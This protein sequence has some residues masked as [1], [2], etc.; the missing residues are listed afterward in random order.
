MLTVATSRQFRWGSTLHIWCF[1]FLGI[2]PHH[3]PTAFS[4]IQTFTTNTH[5]HTCQK[6]RCLHEPAQAGIMITSWWPGC[7][8]SLSVGWRPWGRPA[9]TYSSFDRPRVHANLM[10][11]WLKGWNLR[12]VA[13][14]YIDSRWLVII[15][16]ETVESKPCICVGV[17][18]L[19]RWHQNTDW[20]DWSDWGW[21]YPSWH[22]DWHEWHGWQDCRDLGS[23]ET[24]ANK[25]RVTRDVCPA[26]GGPLRIQTWQMEISWTSANELMF[27]NVSLEGWDVHLPGLF[28]DVSRRVWSN[29]SHGN[30]DLHSLRI[31]KWLT[32]E[33]HYWSSENMW[34]Y[35]KIWSINISNH[36]ST[37]CHHSICYVNIIRDCFHVVSHFNQNQM[38]STKK[39]WR[40]FEKPVI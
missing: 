30:A 39:A 26:T 10:L 33:R 4:K 32:W 20:S 1:D 5:T 15:V 23:G 21:S 29:S 34:K 37:M 25:N 2:M 16:V 40:A 7:G 9:F 28:A 14:Y 36:A 12:S 19:A 38:V 22:H 13:M 6:G 24:M 31:M 3:T 17:A 27:H 11:D 35:D 18:P 8:Q